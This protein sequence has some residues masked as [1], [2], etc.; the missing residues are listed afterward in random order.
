MTIS[1]E[2]QSKIERRIGLLGIAMIAVLLL[3]ILVGVA[4]A[5]WLGIPDDPNNMAAYVN[6]GLLSAHM[7]VGTALAVLGVWI[8][9]DA[10]R[11]RNKRWLA[12][13]MVGLVAVVAAFAA[14]GI[15]LASAG[16]NDAASFAMAIACLVAL[17]AY[18]VPYLRKVAA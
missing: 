17:A 4:S 18:L 11:V 12:V 3:Q 5:L 7:W 1:A 10:Y 16:K 6:M 14:G 9:I 2:R 15:F 13:S 8:P